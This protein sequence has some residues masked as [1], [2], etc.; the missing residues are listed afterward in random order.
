M[1]SDSE[2]RRIRSHPLFQFL[3]LANGKLHFSTWKILPAQIEAIEYVGK[4]KLVPRRELAKHL[5][6]DFE[7]HPE[8][9]REHNRLKTRFYNIVSPL[10]SLILVG[11]KKTTNVS[12]A[13]SYD[14][15]RDRMNLLRKSAEYHLRG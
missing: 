2:I 8:G 13:L 6:F 14:K 5:G 1:L 9:T 4:K 15:F 10:L 3:V 11:E 7:A 12:Y